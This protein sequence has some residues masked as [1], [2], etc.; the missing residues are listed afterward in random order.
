MTSKPAPATP[1][2]SIGAAKSGGA[3]PA[4]PVP[5][6]TGHE[7][8]SGAPAGVTAKPDKPQPEAPLDVRL[9]S[10]TGVLLGYDPNRDDWFVLERPSLKLPA[11]VDEA[12][13]VEKG[14]P[15]NQLVSPAPPVPMPGDRRADTLAAPEPFDSRL[16]LGDGLCR[17]WVIGGS[18]ARLL[19]PSGASRFGIELR[20]G[21]IVLRSG[22]GPN[23]ASAYTPLVVT[24][25]VRGEQWQLEFLQPDTQCGIEI[26]PL[27][28]NTPGE[29]AKEV[30][31]SGGLYVVSGDVRF[32]EAVGRQRT[33]AAGRWISLAPSDLAV[34]TDRSGSSF[35]AK[36][37]APTWLTPETHKIPPSLTRIAKDFGEAFLS[38]QPVSL[39]I[40][41]LAKSEKNPMI[42][43]LA[44][45]TLALTGQYAS[46][47]EV[48]AQVPHDEAVEAAARGL[49]AWLPMSPNHVAAL[50][51]GAEHGLRAG[52]RGHCVAAAVGLQ[53]R[54]RPQFGHIQA[55]R[56]MAR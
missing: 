49:R 56:R 47:V 46:L 23:P 27:F 51:K 22:L 20:E 1:V 19:A 38:D 52:C 31:Y 5:G 8:K 37:A 21:R 42:A 10:K 13:K 16:D 24:L 6:I 53:R 18:S 30:S 43:E 35:R 32:P 40:S 44:A 34:A 11:P 2:A 50:A 33:L 25:V 39:S 55:A 7:P 14:D 36:G 3:V 54:R 28:P 48:L 45:K 12:P 15:A 29:D 4:P 17:L 9:V 41:T 26:T